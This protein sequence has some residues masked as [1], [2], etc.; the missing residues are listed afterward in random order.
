MEIKDLAGLSKPISKLIDAFQ[1]GCSWVMEPT[2]VKRISVAKAE[3][4][5]IEST[6]D[7]K[8][9]LKD[10][11]LADTISA[12]HTV[13][14]KRQFDNVAS[15]YASAAQ[16]LIMIE[17]VDDTPVDIDWSTRFFDY[18]KDISDEE[19]QIVWAKILAGEIAK[20][21]SFFKRTLSVLRDI[22]TFEAKWFVDICQF[23]LCDSVLFY[24]Q[25]MN[26]YPYNQL[27]SLMDCGLIN[28]EQCRFEIS[29]NFT[30]FNGK[31]HSLKIVDYQTDRPKISFNTF[32]LTDAGSQLYEI[33]QAQTNQDFILK[34]KDVIEKNNQLKLEIIQNQQ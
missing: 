21:G 12:T 3:A 32:S 8:K 30:E 23:V 19:A 20:P 27:Q 22:E 34:L 33:T 24:R 9:Y 10:S 13:R 11:L 7:F 18:S 31:T 1:S 26:N 14:E 29:E 17:S 4:A 15:I 5:S 28:S 16:E 2:Q 25:F 6:A